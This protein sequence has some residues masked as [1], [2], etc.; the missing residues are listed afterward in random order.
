MIL[1]VHNIYGAVSIH[2]QCLCLVSAYIFYVYIWY[3]WYTIFRSAIHDGQHLRL[4]RWFSIPSIHDRHY[5]C[6][7]SMIHNIYVGCTWYRFIGLVSTMHN[8]CD[9]CINDMRNIYE[10]LKHNIF[11][12]YPWCTIFMPGSRFWFYVR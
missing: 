10:Y 11:V 1:F 12:W 3:P 8:I 7:V 6:L 9:W 4:N 5:L 2:R